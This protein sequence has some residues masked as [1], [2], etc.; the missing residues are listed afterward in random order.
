MILQG[1]EVD[2]WTSVVVNLHWISHFMNII[3]NTV[4]V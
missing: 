4:H 2:E 3:D 1:T